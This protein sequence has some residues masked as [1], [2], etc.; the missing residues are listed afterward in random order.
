MAMQPTGTPSTKPVLF[1]DSAPDKGIKK[2]NPTRNP[3]SGQT[4]RGLKVDTHP[5]SNYIL[6]GEVSAFSR[7]CVK[8]EKTITTLQHEPDED[9]A[10]DLEIQK[11]FSGMS[12]SSHSNVEM[13]QR[14]GPTPAVFGKR[15]ILKAETKR[16]CKNRS[17]PPKPERL[18]SYPGASGQQK[19][20]GVTLPTAFTRPATT[21]FHP[22]HPDREPAPEKPCNLTLPFNNS[23]NWPE[24]SIAVE[25]DLL[26]FHSLPYDFAPVEQPL[27]K[28]QK[29]GESNS[30]NS[31]KYDRNRMELNHSLQMISRE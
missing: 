14:S 30:M 28:Y 26:E 29:T 15:V 10:C 3:G 20:P 31:G 9:L 24:P 4:G 12:L 2:P 19:Q 17:G 7:P 5:P 8:F 18:H 13:I 21:M 6:P 22:C 27:A 1:W 11:A 23:I 25:S 16:S